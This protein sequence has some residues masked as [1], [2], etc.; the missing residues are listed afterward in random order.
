MTEDQNRWTLAAEVKPRPQRRRGTRALLVATAL[1][2]LGAAVVSA[3]G[4][5]PRVVGNPKGCRYDAGGV[6][7]CN[8]PPPDGGTP[9]R[10]AGTDGGP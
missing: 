9:N 3:C 10:D 7:D 1:G 6:D 8:A 4:L 5:G 2:A